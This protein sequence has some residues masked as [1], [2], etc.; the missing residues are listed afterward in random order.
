MCKFLRSFTI[1]IFSKVEITID[2]NG[3]QTQLYCSNTQYWNG[4]SFSNL[5]SYSFDHCRQFALKFLSFGH[6]GTATLRLSSVSNFARSHRQ[7]LNKKNVNNNI[8]FFL[9]SYCSKQ[10]IMCH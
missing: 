3:Q 7:F 10:N 1:P 2:F 4:E 9:E 5:T 8:T 6:V